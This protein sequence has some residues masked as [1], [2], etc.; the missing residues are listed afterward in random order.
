MADLPNSELLERL[1]QAQTRIEELKAGTRVKV[2][3]M[4]AEDE[5]GPFKI[6]VWETI[7]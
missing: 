4:D 6:P 3:F 2:A 7:K 1:Q 5:A